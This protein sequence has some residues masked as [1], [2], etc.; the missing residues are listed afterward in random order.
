MLIYK[1]PKSN[2]VSTFDYYIISYWI[3]TL[4]LIK[5]EILLLE[6]LN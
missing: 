5:C 3:Q 2:V 1:D 4:K 6:M